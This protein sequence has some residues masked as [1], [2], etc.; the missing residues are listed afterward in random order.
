MVETRKILIV[1]DELISAHNLADNLHQLGYQV[2]HIAK[3]ADEAMSAVRQERPDLVL[4]DI[5]LKGEA[6]GI[7]AAR[8]IQQHQIPVIYLTAFSDDTTLAKASQ[9]L[10]YGYLSKPAKLEDI[11]SALEIAW[12]RS[13]EEVR[14][15]DINAEEKR[16]NQLKSNFYMMLSH[17]LRTPLSV[18]LTS[19]EIVREYGEKLTEARKQKHF[20][21]MRGAIRQM[22]HQLETVMAAEQLASGQLPFKPQPLDVV[23]FIKERV[24]SFQIMVSEAQTLVFV[25]DQTTHQQRVDPN[26]LEHILNNLISNAIKYSPEGHI[27]VSL[28]CLCDG[29]ASP[30]E[31]RSVLT[32]QDQGIG[33][34]QAFLDRLFQLFAR[35]DNVGNIK[36]TGIGMHVVKNAV[37]SHQGTIRVKSE[38]GVGTCFTVTLPG[39]SGLS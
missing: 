39:S 25:S 13:E 14:M 1:E 33:M 5:H 30:V 11:K 8:S 18:L 23:K 9:T 6:T 37:D 28:S 15:R 36:G 17:D 3:T 22:T 16:L 24:E 38:Q 2:T 27:Q 21:Q 34:P 7:D 26:L 4:M 19:L 32:V 29:S 35:A 12:V 10:P 31:P 20:G